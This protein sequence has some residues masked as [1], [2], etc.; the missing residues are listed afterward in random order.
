MTTEMFITA[1]GRDRPGVV[2]AITGVLA[3]LD[4]N[5][6]DTSMTILGGRFAM[7]LLVLVP[8]EVDAAAIEEAFAE[9]ARSLHLDVSV[10]PVEGPVGG[11]DDRS[12]RWTLSVYGVDH[13][14]IVHGVAAALADLEVNIVDMRTR[15]VGAAGQP[16]YAMTLDVL[17]PP[18]GV[19]LGE[20]LDGVAAELG[21]ECSL[22]PVET[23]IL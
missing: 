2:A 1:V 3:G 11:E 5:L 6:E 20:R 15:V 4:A 16:V 21:V 9:P 17:V 10:H 23:D 12:E 13:P 14:G 7:V 8:D 19:G 18:S 22:H